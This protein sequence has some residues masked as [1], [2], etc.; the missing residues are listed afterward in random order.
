MKKRYK[1]YDRGDMVVYA[2][3]ASNNK[4]VYS[5]WQGGRVRLI[6]NNVAKINNYILSI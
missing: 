6:T 3:L 5:L 2:G 1:I 4:L